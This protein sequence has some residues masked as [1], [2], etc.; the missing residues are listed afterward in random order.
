MEIELEQAVGLLDYLGRVAWMDG[1]EI[2]ITRKGKPYLKLVAH[3]EGHIED[4]PQKPIPVDLPAAKVW[5]SPEY[6][7]EDMEIIEAFEGKYSDDS[8]FEPFLVHPEASSSQ[9]NDPTVS[10]Q[11]D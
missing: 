11:K 6:F 10:P 3:P 7:E 9:P 1:G 2:T 4:A 8:L 5:I